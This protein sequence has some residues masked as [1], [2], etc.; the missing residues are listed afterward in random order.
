[1]SYVPS[2]TL[3]TRLVLM[4]KVLIPTSQLC[5]SFQFIIQLKKPK[6]M[7]IDHQESMLGLIGTLI[8]YIA[9]KGYY[10]EY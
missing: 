1:M 7:L 9:N 10:G 3:R 2:T 5:R 6:F 8:L 4:G